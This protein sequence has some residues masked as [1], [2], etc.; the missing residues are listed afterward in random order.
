MDRRA[1]RRLRAALGLGLTTLASVAADLYAGDPAD[2]VTARDEAAKAA[3]SGGDR[4]LAASIRKLRRPSVGA[5]YVNVAARA[6]L[7]ALREWLALGVALREAQAAFDMARVRELGAGRAALENRVVRDLTAH[8]AAL[9]VTASAPALE[10]VRGTLRAALADAR[11]AD[12]VS[13]GCLDRAL[14]YGGFGE[15]DMSAALAVLAAEAAS[16]A[17]F[18]GGT[19]AQGDADTDAV[20]GGDEPEDET[21]ADGGRSGPDPALVAALETAEH[22]LA[23]AEGVRDASRD[24]VDRA[25]A[26]LAVAQRELREARSALTTAQKDADA[27]ARRVAKARAA[28][29]GD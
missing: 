22:E 13:T 10:E 29:A 26:A 20:T 11:A 28:L 24:A 23:G 8:L 4:E 3:R 5:W 7:V 9:G 1:P 16:S 12:A 25:E 21:P 18:E 17:S 19:D 6:S 14:S 15:V 27:A 2:F